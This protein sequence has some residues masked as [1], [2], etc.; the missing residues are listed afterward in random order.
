MFTGI[1]Q[2][3]GILRQISNQDSGVR[4][5][6]DPA[7]WHHTPAT[8]DSIAVAGVC[9]TLAT[10]PDESHLLIFDVVGETLQKTTLGSLQTESRVNLEPA[11]RAGAG[12]DGHV[13]QGHVDATASVLTINNTQDDYRIRFQIPESCADYIIPKGS[14]T[15]DGVSL[16]IASVD[17]SSFDIALIPTTLERTTLGQLAPSDSVNI[18]CDILVKTIAHLYKRYNAG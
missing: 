5:H 10:E 17:E 7:G 9:L 13:V 18:E 3:K 15:I 14:I 16:T 2:T 4:L 11:L 12:I 1:I 6:I 8:G